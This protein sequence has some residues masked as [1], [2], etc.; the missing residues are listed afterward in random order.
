VRQREE[1]E[2]REKGIN[3]KEKIKSWGIRL[4]KSLIERFIEAENN[5]T[6]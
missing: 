4:E 5:K 2:E 1:R 3:M 6:E